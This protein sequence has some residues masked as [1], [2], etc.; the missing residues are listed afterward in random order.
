[1]VITMDHGQIDL[2]LAIMVAMTTI[3]LGLFFGMA[4]VEGLVIPWYVSQRR[5]EEE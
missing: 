5:A 2:G 1:M 4:W 3:G